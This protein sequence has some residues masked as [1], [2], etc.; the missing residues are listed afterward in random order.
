MKLAVAKVAI[1]AREALLDGNAEHRLVARGRDLLLVRQAGGVAVDRLVHAEAARLAGHLARELGLVAGQRLRHH[2]GGVIGGLCDKPLD[3]V[4]DRQFLSRLE[5]ELGRRLHRRPAAETSISV[6]RLDP[7]RLHLL[8]QQIERHDLGQRRRVA[9]RVGVGLVQR[10][11]GLGVDDDRGVARIVG[12]RPGPRVWRVALAALLGVGRII[13]QRREQREDRSETQTSPTEPARG[14]DRH[15]IHA[16]LPRPRPV[17]TPTG[18]PEPLSCTD[19]PIRPIRG[20]S[21]ANS[22][23]GRKVCPCGCQQVKTNQRGRARFGAAEQ[24]L[25]QCEIPLAFFVQCNILPAMRAVEL[26]KVQAVQVETRFRPLSG[27]TETQ[28]MTD[29]QELR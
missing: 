15:A 22:A 17:G 9:R 13:G 26:R 14:S 11:A 7:P 25:V 24:I 20:R 6:A 2:D 18:R 19:H 28:E 29:D 27:G 4:F 1:V 21:V 8:E 10:R 23:Q 12:S 3:G 16:S 5:A